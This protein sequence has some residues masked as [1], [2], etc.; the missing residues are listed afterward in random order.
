MRKRS[1]EAQAK[2]NRVE[3]ALVD[4]RNKVYK[5]VRAAALAHHVPVGTLRD[6]VK[7]GKSRTE[8]N[9]AKQIL[10][11]GEEKALVH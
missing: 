4:Y 5:S 6:R 7:G 3:A 8:A 11:A 2:N 10:A 1:K 9:K